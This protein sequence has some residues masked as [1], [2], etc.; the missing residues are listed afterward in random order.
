MENSNPVSSRTGT[1]LLIIDVQQGLFQKST[2]IYK[3]KELLQNIKTLVGKA[4]RADVP[5]FYIQHSN[6]SFLLEGTDGWRLHPR[7]SPEE[8]DAFVQKKHGNAFEDTLLEAQLKAK[9]VG[10]LV[11]T[12]LVTNGCVRAT[13]LGAHQLGYQVI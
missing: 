9:N 10:V 11:I 6:D 3:A 1:A 7:L 13:C 4:R 12:G 2:P 8:R 5:V